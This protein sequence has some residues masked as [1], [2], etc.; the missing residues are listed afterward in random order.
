M[1]L[2]LFIDGGPALVCGWVNFPILWPHTPMQMKLK[3][4][5]PGSPTL[6]FFV[7]T[8]VTHACHIS[9]HRCQLGDGLK[10]S[11]EERRKLPGRGVC[12]Q[13]KGIGL[14]LGCPIASLL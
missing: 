13:G 1:G 3:C 2:F 4:P 14:V 6:D 11:N 5:P 8:P 7:L 9:V 12:L 10:Q